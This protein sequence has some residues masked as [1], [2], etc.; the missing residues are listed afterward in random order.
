M[1]TASID[2]SEKECR[3][4]LKICHLACPGAYSAIILHLLGTSS[5]T[6][7]RTQFANFN[8]STFY[9]ITF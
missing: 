3:K 2:F 1:R 4:K 7:N 9:I 5:Y 6:G 8:C